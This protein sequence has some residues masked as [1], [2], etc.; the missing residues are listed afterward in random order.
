MKSIEKPSDIY[1]VFPHLFKPK[2]ILKK[3][4]SL[5]QDIITRSNINPNLNDSDYENEE[6][7]PS[8]SR[9]VSAPVDA[10]P[11]PQVCN[12]FQTILNK[13]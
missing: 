6:L 3:S 2:S 7:F 12:I 13:Q 5:D 9:T 11:L 8:M 1:R 4:A 10:E